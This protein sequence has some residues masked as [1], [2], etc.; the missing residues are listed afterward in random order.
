MQSTARLCE[1]LATLGHEVTVFTSNAGLDADTGVPIGTCTT[2]NGVKVWYFAAKNSMG[3]HSHGMTKS[4][5]RR[6]SEFDILHV[7]GIW[8]TTS[9]AACR[10]AE[11]DRVSYVVSPRGA[12]GTYSWT[13]KSLKK[14]LY[15][16]LF[17]KRNVSRA[18]GIHY[19]S[20]QELKECA[21]LRLP[22][23][24]R[25]IPNALNLSQWHHDEVA[26]M[27]WRQ[28]IGLTENEFALIN[29]GRLHHKKGLDLLPVVL[30]S[31]SQSNWRMVFIGQAEDETRAKLQ[32]E[33]A[34]LGLAQRV[35]FLDVLAPE[36]LVGAYSGADLFLMPSRHENFGNVVI[37]ALACG[38]PVV[39]SDQVGV[40]DQ[41][42][43]LALATVLP[44]DVEPW[45][46]HL[47]SMMRR[48]R[49]RSFP[50]P[51]GSETLRARF[52]P[53]KTAEAMATFYMEILA[54]QSPRPRVSGN[55]DP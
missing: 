27:Q 2:R 9:V 25:I 19:T 4:V 32:A 36:H 10:A 42:D 40:W 26:G 46:T 5:R 48:G 45:T 7:T 53:L 44:R 15:Y 54:A 1:T 31:L 38:C 23:R 39:L 47:E 28:K 55:Q 3:I 43:D 50:N 33:F 21:H 18:A 30:H 29:I 13:Q 51:A 17:E 34:R 37:E 49:Q 35:V 12:L 22:G 41:V 14:K 20:R 6:I 16:L 52:D 11:R 24:T 8:Q